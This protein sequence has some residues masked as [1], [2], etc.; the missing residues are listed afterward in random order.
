MLI[1]LRPLRTEDDPDSSHEGILDSM[2]A[3]QSGQECMAEEPA[4]EGCQQWSECPVD[5]QISAR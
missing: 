2:R 3:L 1:A 5:V 4:L